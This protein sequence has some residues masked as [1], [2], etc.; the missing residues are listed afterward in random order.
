MHQGGDRNGIRSHRILAESRVSELL[1][2]ARST[3]TLDK[4]YIT[5]PARKAK[6][7]M[8]TE[9]GFSEAQRL[10]KKLFAR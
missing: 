3:A 5:D 2:K 4:G 7:V 10:F 6:S 1:E 9:L 8:L